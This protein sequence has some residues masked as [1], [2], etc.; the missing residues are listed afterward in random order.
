MCHYPYIFNNNF[1]IKKQ[2]FLIAFVIWDM[3]VFSYDL[4]VFVPF[5]SIRKHKY[6]S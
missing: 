2:V 4:S 6:S 5:I 3:K 1:T